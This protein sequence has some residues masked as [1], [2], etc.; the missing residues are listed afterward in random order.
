MIEVIHM[1]VVHVRIPRFWYKVF[2]FFGD[3]G[4]VG[5]GVCVCVCVCAAVLGTGSGVAMIL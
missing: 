2:I 4:T 5:A 3:T 1:L